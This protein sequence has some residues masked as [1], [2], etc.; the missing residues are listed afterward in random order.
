M[1]AVTENTGWRGKARVTG[2]AVAADRALGLLGSIFTYA[3]KKGLVD[4]SPVKG[5]DREPDK[6][7]TRVLS[8]GEYRTLGK[9]IEAADHDGHRKP[10]LLAV[11]VL[12]LTGCRRNE[13]SCNVMTL[14]R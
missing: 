12:A 11:L 2:G 4:S 1:T 5:I 14:R 13:G 7:R 3:I 6:R 10:P 9:A 8:P